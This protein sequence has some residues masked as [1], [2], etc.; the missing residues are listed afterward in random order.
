[1]LEGLERDARSFVA[2]HARAYLF[3]HAA[4]VG[5]N[6][7]AIVMPGKSMSGKTSMAVEFVRAGAEYYSDEF[8]VFDEAGLVHPY[9]KP[10][11]IRDIKDGD[12]QRDY[13][14]EYF[15]GRA[16]RKP[17]RVGLVL[18]THYGEGAQWRPR[19]LSPGRGVMSLLSNAVGARNKSGTAIEILARAIEKA[20]ILQGVR[21]EGATVV[22][23]V[24]RSQHQFAAGSRGM[25]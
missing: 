8:A 5:W 19:Q 4:V 9:A 7:L 10:L 18:A 15:G 12:R 1:M 14:V 25:E 13:P 6:G 24:L 3:V 22:K 23:S 2:E 16:G 20:T 21:G 11:S 17:V